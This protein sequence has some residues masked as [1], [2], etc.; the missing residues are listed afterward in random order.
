MTH[1]LIFY[2]TSAMSASV[3]GSTLRKRGLRPP[4]TPIE[5]HPLKEDTMKMEMQIHGTAKALDKR[6]RPRLNLLP[7][8]A[9]FDRLVDVILH[10]RGADNRM[11]RRRQVL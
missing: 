11:N 10:N 3:G 7:L 5:I 8:D 9:S 6:Y 2:T 1:R 4:A